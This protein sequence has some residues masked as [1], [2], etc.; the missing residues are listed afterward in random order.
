MNNIYVSIIVPVYNSEKYIG[1]CIES[2]LNQTLEEIEIIVINDGST[3]KSK[4]IIDSYAQADI[5]IKVINKK[6]GGVSSARNMGIDAS[7]GQYI[8]FVDS[9]DWCEPDMFEKMYK[10]AINSCVDLINI[11]YSVDNKNGKSKYKEA[12]ENFIESRDSIEI[13][14]IMAKLPLGYSVMK[15]Y[16]KVIIDEHNIKFNEKLSLG[17]DLV[18][19]QDYILN[20]NSIAAINEYSY[21]YVK[22]NNESLSTKYVSNIEE[23]IDIFWYKEEQIYAKFPYYRELREKDG[24]TKNIA[25][26]ILYIYNN[27]RRGCNLNKIQKLEMIK[28]IMSDSEINKAINLYRPNKMSHK[29]FV[30]LYKLKNEHIMHSTYNFLFNT[31]RNLK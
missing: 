4:E 18:F 21:H 25:A 1:R 13:S 30:F 3:D 11:G 31:I 17:E 2:L 20:I 10:V 26:P 12:V 22:C 16:R 8:T 19:V 7:N 24:F 27:Y 5:R 15:L 29:L 14:K 23:F 9:D 6:N 28:N